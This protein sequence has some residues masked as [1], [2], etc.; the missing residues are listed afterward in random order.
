MGQKDI[1]DLS[2]R[3]GAVRLPDTGYILACD[4]E[5][6]EKEIPHTYTFTWRSGKFEQGSLNFDAHTTCIV[7]KPGPA[8][9]MLAAFGEYGITTPKGKFA[10]NIFD[11]SSEG[12]KYGAFRV[13]TAIDGKAYAAGH[14][15]MVF[16]LDK[17]IHWV[18]IDS[19]L[20]NSFKITALDGYNGDNIYAAGY[21]GELWHY[22]GK[23][24]TRI[25]LPTNVNLT[26]VKC[27]GDGYVYVSGYD[28]ILLRGKEQTWDF[29]AKDNT[30]QTFWDI[31]W[32]EDCLYI[33]TMLFL[34]R[35]KENDLEQVQFDGDPPDTCYHLSAA[36][37]V[38]WSIGGSDIMSFDGR[39]WTRVV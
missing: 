31:E 30:T 17:F 33:S 8:W 35:L 24:W 6:E 14:S 32:F 28:G 37:G 20:P 12:E 19:G 3:A 2:I 9:V 34:Y 4:T 18:P 25:D 36:K 11:G 27:A 1:S 39:N 5:K 7:S 23:R 10:G 21:D 13:V 29:I 16:R 26:A 38:M 15:G 22:D